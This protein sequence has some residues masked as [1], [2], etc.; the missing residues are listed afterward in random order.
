MKQRL[1]RILSIL[2]I[3][4]LACGCLT[5]SAFADDDIRLITL[6]WD[7]END[8]Q[9]IRPSTATATLAGQTVTLEAKTGW[10]G[11]VTVP[12]GTSNNWTCDAGTDYTFSAPV[13]DSNGNISVLTGRLVHPVK[14]T[15]EQSATVTWFDDNNAAKIRPEKVS[16]NLVDQ[17]SQNDYVVV[18]KAAEANESNSW[19]VS[20][21]NLYENR[22]GSTV[23]IQYAIKAV[24][25]IPGYKVEVSGNEVIYTLEKCEKLTL[26]VDLNPPAGADISGLHLT[27]SGPYGFSKE[28]FYNDVASGFYDF[29]KVPAGA[30]VVEDQNAS[31]LIPGYVIDP[32]KS[33]VADGV[34]VDN[35]KQK[36]GTLNFTFTW[37]KEEAYTPEEGYKPEDNYKKLEFQVLGP[38]Y[39][40]SFTYDQFDENGQLKIGDL[41]PGTYVVFETNPEGLVRKYNL[42][43]DSTTGVATLVEA[44]KD[45][46]AKLNNKYEAGY[47]DE[48]INIPVTKIWNDN[49]NRDGN[50]PGS[51]TVNLQANGTTVAS[52][53]LTG[54]EGWQYVFANMPRY[55]DNH[56]EITYT[57]NENPVAWY[58]GSVNGFFVTNDY[59]PETTT[60]SVYK[61]WDD[62]DNERNLRPK[63]IAVT[64]LPTGKIYMLTA[65]NDW[66]LT[67]D[68]LP[69]KLNGEDVTY[70]WK[71]EETVGYVLAGTEVSGNSVVFYNHASNVPKIPEWMPQAKVPGDMWFIFEEY[72]TALGGEILINHVGDCFD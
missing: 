13:T 58:D 35:D 1:L 12:E 21:G 30:Y 52:H 70:S 53:T 55:D 60:A 19:S 26:N 47:D 22:K 6:E 4:A 15:I 72:E 69:T 31:S 18:R 37:K 24:D 40:N 42:Q 38:N 25:N 23:P 9:G 3:L 57:I 32:D 64:L 49:G 2:C 11:T 34:Y 14:K 50:R 39:K 5:L 29:G 63:N 67:V 56:K 17:I 65:A 51:I 7:D 68:N 71:E 20:W 61:I 43:S 45:A 28:L 46:I 33:N 62:N 36:E 10:T 66:S 41:L 8:Y 27:V 44:N 48:S 16:V 54:D 59:N